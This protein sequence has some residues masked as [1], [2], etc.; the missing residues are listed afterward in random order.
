MA[1]LHSASFIRISQAYNRKVKKKPE[2]IP[3]ETE[4]EQITEK[5]AEVCKSGTGYK[6]TVSELC[7]YNEIKLKE[8]GYKITRVVSTYKYTIKHVV[9]SWEPTFWNRIIEILC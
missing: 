1:Y 2:S 6:I 5:I 9:I 3:N 4:L 8:K 7:E